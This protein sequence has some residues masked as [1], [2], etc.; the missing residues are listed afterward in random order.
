MRYKARGIIEYL[1]GLIEQYGEDIE[2][3]KFIA[4]VSVYKDGKNID[5]FV[6]MFPND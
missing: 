3:D 1:E 2:I 4:D 5:G 6:T